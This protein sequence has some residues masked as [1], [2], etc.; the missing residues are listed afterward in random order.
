M[1]ILIFEAILCTMKVISF[2]ILMLREVVENKPKWPICLDSLKW[3]KKASSK[4]RFTSTQ[5]IKPD[6]RF[7]DN[8]CYLESSSISEIHVL[9]R[10]F[11]C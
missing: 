3:Y 6:V 7:I 2:Q 4:H 10:F 1:H 8:C 11:T 5:K 9:E